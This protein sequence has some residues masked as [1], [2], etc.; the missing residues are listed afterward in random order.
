MTKKLILIDGSGFIFRAYHAL[1]PLKRPDGT[2]VG[3]VYG[4]CN[5]LQKYLES[6]EGGNSSYIAVIF[7]AGR[8][9]FRQKIYPEYKAHRPEPPEDL[10]PQ[11]SIIRQATEAFG[12]PALELDGYEAD[13]LIA[14]YAHLAKAQ[15]IEVII[16]SSDKDL[17][18]LI[19]DRVSMIDPMKNKPI[20]VPEVVEKFGVS[21]SQVIDVQALI[22]DASDNV[23]GVPGI[24]VKTAAELINTFGSLESLLNR[25]DEIKQPK[26]RE[27]LM[28]YADQARIS[29]ELVTL[30]TTAPVPEPLDALKVRELNL[31][32]LKSF[33]REQGFNNLIARLERKASSGSQGVQSQN[34][35]QT[36]LTLANMERL[37]RELSNQKVIAF[38]TETTSLNAVEAELVGISLSFKQEEGYYIPL[39]HCEATEQLAV[40]QV[41]EKL[42]PVLTDPGILKIGHNLKYDLVVLQKY[43]V[44]IAPYADTMLMSY[45]LDAGKNGHGMDELAERHLGYQTIKYTDVTGTGKNQKRFDEVPIALA[46][47]YAAEDADITLRLYHLFQERLVKEQMVAV[48]ETI[49]RPLVPVISRME[50]HGIK[51]NQPLLYRLGKD[52]AEEMQKLEL[53]IY[54][55]AGH[56][57]NIGSPKQLGEV[58]F[59]EQNM[60]QPKKTKTGTF[61]TDADVLEKL[62]AQGYDLPA[63]V[64]EWRGLAK[65]KSTYIDGLLASVNPKTQRIHTSF[66]MAATTTGRLSSSEP[67]LQNI[68][69]RTENGRKIREAFVPESGYKIVSLDY[70]QI[71]LRLLANMADV[72]TLRQAF[73]SGQDIHTATAAEIFGLAMEQVDSTIRRQAKAINF[74]IIYGIS[75]Y[76]LSQQLNIPQSEA[77]HYI[78]AYFE[79]YPGIQDYM[80][81][82]KT[83]AREQGYVQTILGRKCYAPGILDKNPMMRGFAERQAINAP[84][85]GSNAD[86]IKK[87]M[88]RIDQLLTSDGWKTRLLLQVHDELVFEVP[89]GELN[90]IIPQLKKIMESI[91]YLPVPLVVEAGIGENWQQAH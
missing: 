35:Y 9:T 47:R 8:V 13:D 61:V 69:I 41:L 30:C 59:V 89:E 87:A 84:L 27:A 83:Q 42:K 52:F 48:Y 51:I 55:L 11:F 46:A 2:P 81:R 66:A 64:M 25:L 45:V 5:I 14:S 22:G 50:G 90:L 80:E 26:R 67:N 21:P 49:E 31:L 3:A 57:F 79:R 38:D 36:I 4:F 73:L 71:E 63:K 6:E 91:I 32:Q 58:L 37:L 86:I 78:K 40:E 82:M 65:L 7:D 17:M 12:L 74:G 16:V 68:P 54:D 15:G 20:S 56:P 85:Q 70:S 53:K 1:P 76:G 72:P 60:P 19:D 29:K 18:Q 43:G 24:G 34:G 28:S 75:A 62:V 33:L 10:I 23:P 44:E 77:A 39:N 88:G